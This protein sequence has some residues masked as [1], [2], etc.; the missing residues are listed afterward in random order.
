MSLVISEG[1][2]ELQV[3]TIESIGEKMDRNRVIQEFKTT[4]PYIFKEN[5]CFA[6]IFGSV[7]KERETDLLFGIIIP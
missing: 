3:N 1:K 7:A 4:I 5:L 2:E 6:F